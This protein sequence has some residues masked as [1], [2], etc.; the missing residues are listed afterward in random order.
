MRAELHLCDLSTSH[1][2]PKD[3]L[4]IPKHRQCF[5]GRRKRPV[6][7][8]V[9]F[10]LLSLVILARKELLRVALFEA[11]RSLAGGV[12]TPGSSLNRRL[13]YDI[14][15]IKSPLVRGSSASNKEDR[16]SLI[17]ST[18]RSHSSLIWCGGGKGRLRQGD[19]APLCRAEVTL[20]LR[21]PAVPFILRGM[22]IGGLAKKK[23]VGS[24]S[25]CLSP[26]N[27]AFS[28]MQNR[29]SDSLGHLRIDRAS[30]QPRARAGVRNIRRNPWSRILGTS[31]DGHFEGPPRVFAGMLPCHMV[32][33]PLVAFID[34]YLYTYKYLLP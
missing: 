27:S 31:V 16:K 11:G 9:F 3:P 15:R 5:G 21:G 13:P 23:P 24:I 29:E 32:F 28:S 7:C 30:S 6:H 12:R 18:P 34:I 4:Q 14:R 19:G 25:G 22:V 2:L 20:P 10:L 1:H 33:H 26:R 8:T 17:P